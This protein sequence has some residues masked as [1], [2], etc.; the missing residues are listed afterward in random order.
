M[1]LLI[2]ILRV[3]T[4]IFIV[5]IIS[6]WLAGNASVISYVIGTVV[7]LTSSIIFVPIT[8]K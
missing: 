6:D 8:I 1:G 3:V 7:L 4:I 2:G 5:F